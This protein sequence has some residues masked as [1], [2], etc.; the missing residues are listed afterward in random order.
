MNSSPFLT[1]HKKDNILREGGLRSIKRLLR[2]IFDSIDLL[3]LF[4]VYVGI[5]TVETKG[6]GKGRCFTS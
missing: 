4:G 5:I 2:V 1:R 6:K 3:A